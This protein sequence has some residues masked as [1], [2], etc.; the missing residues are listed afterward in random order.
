MDYSLRERRTLEYEMPS[1]SFRLET[2][3]QID[4]T[5]EVN[6]SL[7]VDLLRKNNKKHKAI[8]L[9]QRGLTSKTPISYA[10]EIIATYLYFGDYEGAYRRF[11]TFNFNDDYLSKIK[12]FIEVHFLVSNSSILCGSDN[13]FVVKNKLLAFL[14]KKHGT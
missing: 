7:Q 5:K 6:S 8:I 10:S 9:L 2:L 14:K 4:S 11:E 1:R 13:F 12:M 3:E